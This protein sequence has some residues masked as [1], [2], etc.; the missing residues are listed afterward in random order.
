MIPSEVM[1]ELD[2]AY[3]QHGREPTLL[4]AVGRLKT[5]F[6][7]SPI[8]VEAAFEFHAQKHEERELKHAHE[9][10]LLRQP[11]TNVPKRTNGVLLDIVRGKRCG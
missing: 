1:L 8:E 2:A 3:A 5:L 11:D 4:E 10:F 7:L 9:L 6:N